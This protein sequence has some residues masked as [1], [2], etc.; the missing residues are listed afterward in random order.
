MRRIIFIISLFMCVIACTKQSSPNPFFVE[1]EGPYELPPFEKITTKDY[2]EAFIKGMEEQVDEIE[3]IVNDSET[4]SFQNTIAAFDASGKLLTKV[5][6]IFFAQSNA[7]GTKEIQELESEIVPLLTQHSDK[8]MMNAKLF[9]K[10]SFVKENVDYSTLTDEETTLLNDLYLNFARNGVLLSEADGAKFKEISERLSILENRF[11]QNLLAETGS[12]QLIIDNEK[13][14]EGLSEGAIT[15]AANR[16]ENAGMAGKWIFGLDNPSIIPFLFSNNNKQLR[17]K[18]FTAYL[19]RCNND[20][21]F[22][23]K[24][25]LKETVV[26]RKNKADLLGYKDF[27]DFVLEKR[28]A[29]NTENVYQLLNQIWSPALKKANEELA[30][31]QTLIGEGYGLTSSDWRY[32]AEKLKAQKYN[33]S[34]EELRPYFKA[35]NVLDGIFWVS[36]QLFGITFIELKDVPKPH[37]DAQAFLC[38]DEDGTTELGVLYIDLY[39]RPGLKRG[40][41][42]CGTYRDAAQN[43]KGERIKPITY[44]T[45][46]FTSPLGDEPSLLTPDEVETYFHEFGH[47]LHNLFKTVKYNLTAHVPTD[48]VELPSQIMEH[49]AFQPQV[50]AYYAKHYKTGESIPQELLDKMEAASKYGQG[51]ATVE[52]LAASYLDMDYHV[53]VSPETINVIEFE[54]NTLSNRGLISQIPPRYRSTYFQHTF[55]GFYAAGYYSY[56]WSEV[57]DCDAF[58]AFVESGDIFNKEIAK[59]FRETILEPG[60]T[61]PADKMYENFRGKNPNIQALLKNRGLE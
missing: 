57:L 40:G 30:E 52:Y 31:M 14:L 38:L 28:M 24:E 23:N 1:W 43:E 2:K 53:N 55:T 36:N 8:I 42:W 49:W 44:I 22:D 45:C 47:A 6:N 10:V 39:A 5:I 59:R 7:D 35:E 50:L 29:K 33:L 9:E 13:D 54:A 60:G 32:Y 27:A 56:I 48:F 17:E 21:E 18:I 46:N 16:A 37:K 11:A 34:D 19:N 4:P 51:F 26:L 25:V 12:F 15:A 20:N 61:Y 3:A 41:A 58:A